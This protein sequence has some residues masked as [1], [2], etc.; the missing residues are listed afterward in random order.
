MN[1]IRFICFIFLFFSFSNKGVISFSFYFGN[2]QIDIFE[3]DSLFRLNNNYGKMK[4]RSNIYDYVFYLQNNVR[5]NTT[6]TMGSTYSVLYLNYPST[7]T[8]MNT[9]IIYNTGFDYFVA[10]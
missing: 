9:S 6:F 10:L 8:N 5:I 7:F 1:C 3:S 2:D 4:T